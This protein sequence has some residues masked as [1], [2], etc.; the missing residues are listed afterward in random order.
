M[1]YTPEEPIVEI[2]STMKEVVERELNIE[3]ELVIGD[4]SL[5]NLDSLEA[6]SAHFTIVENYVPF[7]TDVK[8]LFPFYPQVFHAFYRS[9]EEANTFEELL[10]GRKVYVG[11]EGSSSNR[12][13]RDLIKFYQVD[14]TQFMITP[15]VWEN[16]VF[17]GFT[18]II[19][20]EDLALF[21]GYKLYSFDD[22]ANFGKGSIAEGISLKYPE[23]GP[24]IIPSETY[25]SLTDTPVLTFES[26]AVL[27]GKGDLPDDVFYDITKLIF[28]DKQEFTKINPLISIDLTENFD[29]KKLKF[30]LAEGSRV[31]LDRDEPSILERYAELAGVGFSLVFALISGVVSLTRWRNQRK[32]DRVDVFYKDLMDIKKDL[33][34]LKTLREGAVHIKRIKEEQEKAFE[35]LIDEKLTADESFRIYMELSKET[36]NEVKLKMKQIKLATQSLN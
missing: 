31:Y 20:A 26:D 33:A 35:M 13:M 15:N 14:T 1:I 16:D 12:F 34:G 25:G 29:R 27:V 11:P 18:A 2:V 3:L 17:C 10:Y 19:R 6:G 23:A 22:V 5:A 30:P 4:G 9:E 28:R 21:E 8:S 36:I 24:F 7:R 32:K